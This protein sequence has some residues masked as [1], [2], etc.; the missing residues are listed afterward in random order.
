MTTIR[1]ATIHD[2]DAIAPLFDAYRQFYG[3]TA[4]LP[5]AKRF[6]SERLTSGESVV[7]LASSSEGAALGYVQL[8]PSFSSVRAVRTYI[9]ND[10]FVASNARGQ[11][12]GRA[13][14]LE[15]THVARA[16]GAARLKLSTAITNLPA[17]G[18]YEAMGWIRDE[19][20]FEYNLAL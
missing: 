5:L 2:I 7:L 1:Q 6:L 18:L 13:L 3:R 20:Y 12:V 4:D 9:L 14:M 17:Q 10:L 19:E 15:S 16:L 11:G 8:F